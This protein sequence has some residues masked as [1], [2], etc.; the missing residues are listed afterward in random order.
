MTEKQQQKI[1]RV[2]AKVAEVRRRGGDDN[3]ALTILAME[4]DDA[5]ATADENLEWA[6]RERRRRMVSDEAL[7]AVRRALESA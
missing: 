7:E 2:A 4:L 3:T 1:D 6:M 5:Q